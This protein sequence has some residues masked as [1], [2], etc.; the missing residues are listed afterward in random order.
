MSAI[1]TLTLTD[2][3]VTFTGWVFK[4]QKL[5]KQTFLQVRDGCS[6]ADKLQVIVPASV[7]TEEYPVESYIQVTG[8]T[9]QLPAKAHSFKTFEIHAT[10]V[11]ILGRSDSD[12]SSR[13]PVDAGPDVRLTERHLYLRHEKF[14]LITKMR[15]CLVSALRDT[16]ESMKCT[17]IFPPSFVGNQCEGGAT[18]FK[19][20]H[21]GAGKEDVDAYL[22][23]SSQFYLEYALPGLGDTY[24]IAPSFRAEHSHTRRHL[25]EFLHAE[26]EWSGIFTFDMHLE[27]LKTLIRGTLRSFRTRAGE[28]LEQYD[29][30]L[31]QRLDKLVA[32]TDDIQ[33]LSHAD[34][35][36]LCREWS[37][38]DPDTGLDFTDR[39]DIPEKAERELIDRIGKIVFLTKFPGEFKSFYMCPDPE[40]PTRVLGCDVEVPGVGEIIGSGVRVYDRDVLIKKLKEQG[41]K[42][43][44]YKEYIDLRKYGHARTSG[45]GLGVD[46]MLTW[47]LECYSIRDVVTFPRYPSRLTP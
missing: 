19:L 13:C 8:K 27:K 24:C 21:P 4:S 36:K 20:K 16:F 43:E 7:S 17:E 25:T 33:V 15:A 42:E 34:A 30:A 37:I 31:L 41:L 29:P 12:F 3:P 26:C 28:Y 14:A 1:S 23:Q 38:K 39:A 10:E 2:Q 44:E 40:D 45:M 6:H 35:I 46:R 5:K 9:A 18:L 22:T 47:L 11:K 32:M